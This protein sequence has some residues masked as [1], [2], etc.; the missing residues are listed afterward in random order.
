MNAEQK[1]IV[2]RLANAN[3]TLWYEKN[4]ATDYAFEWGYEDSTAR[5]KAD[6]AVARL[7]GFMFAYEQ[8]LKYRIAERKKK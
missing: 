4:M 7:E 6:I 3:Q 5:E 8:F 2:E 1:L